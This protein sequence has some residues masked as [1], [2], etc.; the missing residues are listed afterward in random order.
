M[1]KVFAPLEHFRGYEPVKSGS[2]E[3]LVGQAVRRTED[4][5]LL[6][7]MGRYVD[8]IEFANGLH[9]SVYR[10]DKPYARVVSI[11][12][13][14]AKDLPGVFGVYTWSDIA[15]GIKPAVATSRMADY[16]S[17]A[18]Y[19]LANGVVRY[20]GEP[21][22]VVLAVDRYIAED[23][24]NLLEVR[25]EP[26]AIE[27]D[28]VKASHPK[29]PLLHEDLIS[30]ILVKRSF[31]KGEIDQALKN[32]PV[33]V[34]GEFRFHRKTPMALEN[35]VYLAEYIKRRDSLMLYSSSQGPGIIR[36]ALAEFLNLPGSRFN[37]ISPDVG[38]GFG[39]KTSL[40]P[41]EMIVCA[42][43]YKLKRSI[44]WT[45]DR[46]EDLISTSQG[47]DERIKAKLALD[48]DGKI[49]GLLAE[50]ISDIGA[51][52]IY[53]WTAGIEPVQVISFMP[54][55]YRVP[56]YLGSVIA[57]TTPKAPTGPY[58][59]VGRP[60]STFVM[61]RLMNMAA[62]K[63]AVDPVEL[64]LKN[65]VTPEEFPYKTPSGI[66]WDRSA[67]T[68]GLKAASDTFAYQERREYQ[69]QARSQG[70]L[71]GIGVAS[72][73]E[74]SGIGSKIS[75]SPGMPINT[76]TDTC[77]L[78][79]DSTGA[80]T[81]AFGC[82]AHGQGHETTLAQVL[83]DELGAN[84]QDIHVITGDSTA[85]PHGT[86]SYASRTAVLSSGA[87]ILA[88]QELKSRMASMAAYLL[89]TSVDDLRFRNSHI[90][91][92]SAPN[93]IEFV[94]LAKTVYSEMGRIPAELRQELSVTKTYDPIFGTTSSATHLVEV[95]V[96]P[97]TF[98]VDIKRY[99]I[100]EDCGRMI[101]PLIV[102]GQIRGA[103]AQGIGAALLEEVVYDQE[104]Q[105]LTASLVD[106]A[107][108]TALEIPDIKIVHMDTTAPNTLGGFRGVGE[109]GT[110][111]S[112][113]AIANAIADA[114]SGFACEVNEL[115]ATP[116]RIF[117]LIN[118]H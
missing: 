104:G 2:G 100:A 36:D 87:G 95:E 19:P 1:S 31:A 117:Q 26:L 71:V 61:E 7:G 6:C 30:N 91:Q 14:K 83:A 98:K 105:L 5:R 45:G 99:V 103:V 49:M 77:V 33:V 108:P 89:N 72:Y 73:A 106:Y 118:N 94:K 92:L 50:V 113:A 3:K 96:D 85:V 35:R 16:Q 48:A 112:P 84:I 64:R 107:I 65:M 110:I 69:A 47:F 44:K 10:S 86:G 68:E 13:E 23:A 58:R 54:G 46:L 40:Y 56:A 80:I 102:D 8:D 82:A 12:T 22:A 4:A 32:A 78:S 53:P 15:D 39:G 37:V 21:I 42:L 28:P 88:A 29:A 20:V 62:K 51:Y 55:P 109:G 9:M 57:V 101:N 43:A 52:S 115:P 18:I 60:T 59:G 81:A 41:E 75:A 111:G 27:N 70:K 24:L 93:Q 38:G 116:E 11:N 67:F 76:G 74:L 97:S 79:L 17:T 63:L 90:E 66:V 114:L 25:L 34:E